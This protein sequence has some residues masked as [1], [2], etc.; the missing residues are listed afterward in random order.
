M[1]VLAGVAVMAAT[2]LHLPSVAQAGI[3]STITATPSALE[4]GGSAMVTVTLT[5]TADA[6]YFNAY[7]AGGSLTVSSGE[8]EAQTFSIFNGN[9]T[10][11]FQA[12]FSYLADGI[13]NAAFNGMA[14]YS[15]SYWYQQFWGYQ[16]IYQTAYYNYT[17][18]GWPSYDTCTGSY[19]QQVGSYPVYYSALGTTT[20]G[21][22]VSGSTTVS[23]TE[24]VAV[25][26]PASL[27]IFG[28]GLLGLAA[29]RRRTAKLV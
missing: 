23:V 7:L 4:E 21:R 11:T 25:P 8:G 12:K 6:G 19:Q 26:E 27:A 9:N 24:T 2:A 17:C 13:Y 22:S 15:E 5:A 10:Q 29:F 20:F 3:I 14:Y 18:G 16:P 1:T 28:V